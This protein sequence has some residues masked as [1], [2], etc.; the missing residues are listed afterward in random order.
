MGPRAS[1][2]SHGAFA[3]SAFSFPFFPFSAFPFFLAAIAPASALST[4]PALCTAWASVT[5]KTYCAS[6][7]IGIK[8]DES[9][10]TWQPR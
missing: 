5:E 4:S 8:W 9:C 1:S 6:C 10:Y 7:R 2:P 3:P